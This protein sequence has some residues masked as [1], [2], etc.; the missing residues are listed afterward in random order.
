MDTLYNTNDKF[1]EASKKFPRF[2]STR[3]RPVNSV[4]GRLLQSIIE[5]I[6][7]V[8][9]AIIDYKKDF[10]IVNYLDRP[11]EFVDYLYYAQIGEIEDFKNFSLKIPALA[12]T[13]DKD[14]FYDGLES[15]A[16]YQDGRIFFYSD[17][18]TV[19]YTYN[20]F[21]YKKDTTKIHIWNVLDDFAWWVGLDRFP[22]E[23]N[24]ALMYRTINIFR[25]RPSS[26]IQGL[27][28]VIKNTLLNYGNIDDEEIK[29]ELPDENNMKLFNSD[30]QTLY[31]ELS[32]FNRDIARTKK[33]DIDYWKNSFAK[34]KY[35]PHAWD[36]E[37][38]NYKDGVG[39][40]NSLKVT[41]VKD[42]DTELGTAVNIY[43]YKKSKEKIEEYFRRADIKKE[44][45]LKLKKYDDIM[46]PLK[47]QYKIT[48]STL[49]EI[50][51]PSRDYVNLYVIKERKTNYPLEPMV[52]C[53]DGFEIVRKN[54]LIEGHRY[55][56]EVLPDNE[57]LLTKCEVKNVDGTVAHNLLREYDQFEYD[58][59]GSIKNRDQK[60]YGDSIY[61][62]ISSTNLSDS[63]NGFRITDPGSQAA[64]SF[65]TEG[66][67][68]KNPSTKLIL[69]H[70]V[71][72]FSIVGSSYYISGKG[73][74]LDKAAGKY[75]LNADENE[76]ASLVIDFY[77]N[78][79]EYNLPRAASSAVSVKVYINDALDEN[80]CY[81][82]LNM[83][84]AARKPE[85]IS[86][87]KY[88][89]VRV[90]IVR[91]KGKPVVENILA[92]RYEIKAWADKEEMVVGAGGYFVL[93]EKPL[94]NVEV[95]ILNHGGTAFEINSVIVGKKLTRANSTYI[96]EDFIAGKDQVLDVESLGKVNL[97]DIT[98]DSYAEYLPYPEYANKSDASQDLYLDTSAFSSINYSSY[99]IKTADNGMKYITVP[100]GKAV[101]EIEIYGRYKKLVAKRSFFEILELKTGSSVK[102]SKSL[103]S[104]IIDN[105]KA[106]EFSSNLL[107]TKNANY[108][109][110]ELQ[111]EDKDNLG[112]AFISS[113][114]KNV[115]VIQSKY[116]GSFSGFY[117]YPK[118][119]VEYIAYN[120][121]KVVQ[122]I[123][124]EA[125]GGED[126]KIISSFSPAIPKG[127]EVLYELKDPVVLEHSDLPVAV[128]FMENGITKKW[129]TT[130]LTPIQ[131][132]LDLG[133]D[134]DKYI[135]SEELSLSEKFN[136]SNSIELEE[137]YLI[138]NIEIELGKYLI[139]APDYINVV[140]EN[141]KTTEY[142]DDNGTRFYVEADGFNKLPHANIVEINELIVDGRP[143]EPSEYEL[144]GGPGFIFWKNEELYGESFTITY[145]YKKPRYLTFKSIDLLYELAGYNVD[146]Y[147][148][149]NNKE[150]R[151]KKAIDGEIF[152]TDLACFTTRPDKITVLCENPCYTAR[153]DSTGITSKIQIKKIADDNSLVVRS[154]YYYI[155][156]NEYW[157]FANKKEKQV[158]RVNGVEIDG[159]ERAGDS[160]ILC[161][162]AKNY[163]RNSGMARK[164]MNA[165]ATFNFTDGSINPGI[166]QAEHYGACETL[167]LWNSFRM[168]L[169]PSAAYDGDAIIFSPENDSAYA[170]MDITKM[171]E[172]GNTLKIWFSGRLS[173]SICEDVFIEGQRL[174]KSVYMKNIAPLT[175]KKDIAA[176]DIS[177]LDLEHHRYYLLAQGSGAVIELLVKQSHKNEDLFSG[178]DDFLRNMTRFN[179]IIE[180]KAGG[181]ETI[182][183]DFTDA[184][185]VYNG[186]EL[187][188]DMR[189]RTG[190]NIDWGLTKLKAFDLENEITKT[191]ALCRNGIINFEADK[192]YIESDVLRLDYLEAVK[193]LYI[194][195]NNYPIQN[196]RGF[197]ISVLASDSTGSEFMS[198]ETASDTNLLAVSGSRLKQFIKVRIEA[199]EGK[200]IESIEVFAAYKEG[201]MAGPKVFTL[202]SGNAVTKI[203]D[204]GA[205]GNFI[206]KRIIY[207]S[208][209]DSSRAR[210]FIR[211]I[212]YD[213]FDHVYTRWFEQNENHIFNDYR[214]FQF[215]I[216]LDEKSESIRIKSFEMEAV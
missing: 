63:E 57:F 171:A 172:K 130:S 86:L 30:G 173:F 106:T 159:G 169:T 48:A 188:K 50:K 43:G 9:D 66:S 1:L 170:Y 214:Y 140:Y 83:N 160:Y 200:E 164:V 6:G 104:V 141:V 19:E 35:I 94:V 211:G 129:T 112:V 189:L 4:G 199:E 147:E 193:T 207:S 33:W 152:E 88:S 107:L 110:I 29:F 135:S 65:E 121:Q 115:E 210:F 52:T 206:L 216:D 132:T 47:V 196:L 93:P 37:V 203:Y 209:K 197:R 13:T 146:T 175:I 34:F 40:N 89:H 72:P 158:N 91:L 27:K 38:S 5:E 184:G 128:G 51:Y 54:R 118:N 155:D 84:T 127:S 69:G 204:V 108:V 58:K 122:E 92:K 26:S 124:G 208:D 85:P 213:S 99:Q 76:A 22:E 56:A 25:L 71:Q 53:S 205:E 16:Y 81:P 3:R 174:S 55:R 31:D 20:R 7:A 12:V 149:V 183:C 2:L 62:F 82:V 114:L 168:N 100:S 215:R 77:G 198:I 97:F 117:L 177:N 143:L 45:T 73:Y 133:S 191:G 119:T 74:T 179:I 79:L 59:F 192:A 11:N 15:L 163:L 195:V 131:I 75:L 49:G 142:R 61:D 138:D 136:I 102:T 60:F 156:G 187:S 70:N 44:L 202:E 165:T 98:A 201:Q 23:T 90:E 67:S 42:L 154:G 181:E 87:E 8:E 194:K 24:K 103:K 137:T 17:P 36:S 64:F 153:I 125:G 46:N 113:K 144:L 166:S 123:T 10:F 167:A 139:T 150:Y 120:T 145:T 157:Y 190:S 180:E 95:E 105:K 178:A 39:Y 14:A 109:E 111:D 68:L 162:E 41:T 101:S 186:L 148:L 116:K 182:Q 134:K 96:T 21:I 151:I 18:E 126:V 185:M 78:Y 176:I 32:G 80:L 161:K 28:N 212:R